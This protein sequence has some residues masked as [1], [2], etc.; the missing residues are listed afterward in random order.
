AIEGADR[1]E[2]RLQPPS[3]AEYG[4]YGRPTVIH[5][6]RTF[7]HIYL[8]LSDPEETNRS[9]SGSATRLLTVTGDVTAPATIELGSDAHL[10]AVRNAVELEGSFKMACV[11]GVFGGVT[12]TLDIA[13][14]VAGLTAA[15]LGTEGVVELLNDER[16]AVA[17]A[18]DRARF[19]SEANSG[20]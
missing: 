4:L 6:P 15:G 10:S 13:P 3:P 18:G 17:T 12:R 14:T 2:P 11:G 9:G 5:T 1:I 16:C 8:A 19:A 7:A 20:R